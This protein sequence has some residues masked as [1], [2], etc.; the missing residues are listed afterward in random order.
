MQEEL[1]AIGQYKH[2]LR[3]VLNDE[4]Y[5]QTLENL[6]F[7]DQTSEYPIS[8]QLTFKIYESY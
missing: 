8:L 5:T 4:T 1:G 6:T 2:S 3:L 7:G